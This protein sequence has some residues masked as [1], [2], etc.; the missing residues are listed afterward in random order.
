[1]RRDVFVSVLEAM[2]KLSRSVVLS[3]LFLLIIV[4]C[5]PL[6]R[7]EKNI[8]VYGDSRTNDDRHVAV[9]EA[10][11]RV[12]PDV[13]FHT[14]D[15]VNEGSV[16]GLWTRFNEVTRSLREVADFY[17]VAGNHDD[18]S[19]YYYD[20]FVLPNN[21]KW[22][23]VDI[24]GIHFILLNSNL[25]LGPGSEQYA[26]LSGD[27]A[28]TDTNDFVIAV[29]H[30]P[31]VASGPHLPDEYGIAGDLLPLF[32]TYDVDVV[33]NGH[34]HLYERSFLNGIYH[35]VTG[36][37]GAPLHNVPDTSLNPYSQVLAITF[38]FCLVRK[39]GNA[40]RIE[41]FDNDMNRIDSFTVEP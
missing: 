13:V 25:D 41:V 24:D 27:L 8:V 32:E 23:S 11:L 40:L 29:F 15:L 22:Y 18:E 34:E 38:H 16:P 10:I 36:G 17:P 31:L 39:D 19:P 14:G 3:F 21:E 5:S 2:L 6:D 4:S 37:G 20:N 7:S 33:F 30:H 26:W 12:S 1:M 9:I 35:V 28:A